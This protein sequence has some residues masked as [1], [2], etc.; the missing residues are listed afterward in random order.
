MKTKDT[1]EVQAFV[2]KLRISFVRKPQEP[3][4]MVGFE[5]GEFHSQLSNNSC[6]AHVSGSSLNLPESVLLSCNRVSTT[7]DS[8]VMK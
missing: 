1:V 2:A 6:S 3:D 5:A 4:K 8:V 7:L